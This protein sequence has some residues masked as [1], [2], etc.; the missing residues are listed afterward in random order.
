M[1]AW[2]FFVAAVLALVSNVFTLPRYPGGVAIFPRL[3]R[4]GVFGQQN[5]NF[6]KGPWIP[7]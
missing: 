7:R 5:S 2:Q 6:P 1:L 3:K 4:P